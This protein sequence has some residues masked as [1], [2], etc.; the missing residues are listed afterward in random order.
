ML[1][2]KFD[3]QWPRKDKKKILLE[4]QKKEQRED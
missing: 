4:G 2:P 3:T 1:T